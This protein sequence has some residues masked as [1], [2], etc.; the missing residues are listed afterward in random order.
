[1]EVKGKKSKYNQ[2]YKKLEKKITKD[3]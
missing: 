3:I 1:M 2:E